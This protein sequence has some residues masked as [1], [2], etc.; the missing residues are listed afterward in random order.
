LLA[1]LFFLLLER[2]FRSA[3]L[4]AVSFA[5]FLVPYKI[6][7]S[8]VWDSVSTQSGGQLGEI[9]LKNPYNKALGTEDLSGM[10]TRFFENARI[11]LSKHFM[12]GIGLHDP[13]SMEKNW[14][15]VL[16]VGLLFL[17]TLYIAFRRN[18]KMLFIAIYLGGCISAT[19]IAL[20]QSWDQMRMVV[21]YIPM[22]LLL[23]IWGIQHLSEKKGYGFLAILLPFFLF[24][25]FFKTLSHSMDKAKANRRVL[26]R[27]INGNRYYGFTPDWQNFLRMSE[28]VGANIP[29]SALVASRKPSMSFIYSKGRD[30]YGMYRFPTEVPGEFLPKLISR[31]GELSVISDTKLSM[32]WP[33]NEQLAIKKLNVAY[34]AEGSEVFGVYNLKGDTSG[35]VADM[36]DRYQ[37]DPIS[38]DSLLHRVGKSSQSCFAVSAD[39]LLQNLR[40]QGVDYVIV[41]SLRS[42]PNMN[43]GNIINNIQRYLYF[44]EHKYTGILSLVHQVGQTPQDE[45]AWLYKIN[46]SLYGL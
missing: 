23:I 30:F 31:T 40:D 11:Y 8:L 21:I 28:W 14:F 29:D 38:V 22:L 6:Y 34:V 13:A 10:I 1:M 45:P 18:K 27:N 35:M 7:K 20:Q 12:I 2:R 4:L 33:I 19:F 15:V 3:G 24:L 37:I 17:I 5:I 25:M 26:V 36:L 46:Y 32:Q 41:A 9:L 16:I 42:N 44:I 43:T 39:S